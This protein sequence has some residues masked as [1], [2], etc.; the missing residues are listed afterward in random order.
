[1][2]DAAL[3]ASYRFCSEIA[4]R[5]AKSFYHAFLFLPPRRRRAMCAL[6]AFLRHTDDLADEP[7]SVAFKAESLR[8][9]RLELDS[10]LAGKD[11]AWPGL[12]ALADTVARHAIPREFLHEVI[13]GVSTDTEPTRFA[14]FA[15]LAG[16][17]YRV[18][19]VVGLCC[20]HI[21]GYRSEGGR[22]ERLAEDCGIALQLTNILRDIGADA[23][24]GRI[25]LPEDDL[26]RFGVESDELAVTGPPSERLRELLAFEAKRAYSYYLG[27][28]Q[29]VPLVAPIGRPVLVYIVGVY[30]SLLDEIVRREYDVLSS[31]VSIS[32]WRKLIIGIHAMGGTFVA[33]DRSAPADAEHQ[34]ARRSA[35]SRSAS[36]P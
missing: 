10:A 24:D 35:S 21:W 2:Q 9:W 20:L 23:R 1:M 19:S 13:D 22:A 32:P 3:K 7:G 34:S 33:L 6:Y 17:C 12:L 4:R 30:R 26:A 14:T 36:S 5:E 16:Y 28:R 25:Y 11:A 31:R 18:A 27:V 15:D 29:L 8:A